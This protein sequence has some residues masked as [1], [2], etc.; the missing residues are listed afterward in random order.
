MKVL[1]TGAAGFIGAHL[2][3]HLSLTGHDVV[4]I[5]RLSDYY[6]RDLKRNRLTNL[7]H[8]EFDFRNLDLRN[9]GETLTLIRD[10]EP[11][12][13]YH[14]AAQPGIR[15]PIEQ[16]SSYIGDNISAFQNIL[17]SVVE[18]GIPN[19]IYA[20]SS[21]VYGNSSEKF[22]SEDAINL[23]PISYYGKTKL[24]NELTTGRLIAGSATKARGLRF[25]TV[26]GPFG[27]PDMAYFR[28]IS[29]ALETA[30]FTLYG[31]GSTLRD[32]TYIDDV[33]EAI[34]KL[35]NEL[36]THSGGY[37]DV[38]NVGGGNPVSV[39]KM[40]EEISQITGKNVD[41]IKSVKNINDVDFT[42]AATD[43]QL[44]LINWK[45]TSNLEYGLNKTINWMSSAEVR[46]EL[47]KWI[48]G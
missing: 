11:E 38:V 26:Y 45:P 21:S 4:G 9:F 1:V 43:R 35:T 42:C 41:V 29:N 33:M 39:N 17:T 20:S 2:S 10:V 30:P 44:Q 46:P 22:L 27:R 47:I 23:S 28:L 8:D 14:L 40:I 12:T 24:L 31:D 37:E 6:S 19:F 36:S 32:F 18:T 15:L 34:E 7:L 5:D 25:F 16:Y 48:N 13:V 3:R